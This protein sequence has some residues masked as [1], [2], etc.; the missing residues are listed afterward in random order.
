MG[1]I[2]AREA[3][4]LLAHQLSG[5]AFS[6]SD[7]VVEIPQHVPGAELGAGAQ[8]EF[9]AGVV[10][11]VPLQIEGAGE[12]A[13]LGRLL[14]VVRT[15]GV[16]IFGAA[17]QLGLEDA[18]FSPVQPLA[19]LRVLEAHLDLV[20]L[21]QDH[22]PEIVQAQRGFGRGRIGGGD[23]AGQQ[24]GNERHHAGSSRERAVDGGR[25]ERMGIPTNR[26]WMHEE[27]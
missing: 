10:E 6:G 27:L 1:Q 22:S 4:I 26:R 15:A 17:D 2:Q 20:V 14:A 18:L 3:F 5:G 24:Q 8:Q 7:V 21:L 9:D 11:G 12:E 19:D 13:Q 25:V 23:T 16:E